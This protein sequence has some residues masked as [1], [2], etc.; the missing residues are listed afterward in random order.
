M[1]VF[2]DQYSVISCQPGT[3]GLHRMGEAVIGC[4]L[5]VTG[6]MI[7]LAWHPADL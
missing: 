3:T 1:S 6:T 4:Q 5:S 7:R 2:S